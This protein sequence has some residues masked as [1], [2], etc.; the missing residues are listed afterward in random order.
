MTDWFQELTLRSL[1]ETRP[2]SEILAEGIFSTTE[3]PV[4]FALLPS[5]SNTMADHDHY[6]P[7]SQGNGSGISEKKRKH[8]QRGYD[9]MGHTLSL[10]RQPDLPEFNLT[11]ARRPSQDEDQEPESPKV[12]EQLSEGWQTVQSE[13]PKKKAKKVPKANSSNYPSIK[14]SHTDSRLQSQV[15]ISDIQNL[16]LYILADG[17][18]PQFVSVRHRPEI[19]KV[20]VLMVPGLEKSMFVEEKKKQEDDRRHSPEDYYPILLK[21][22]NLPAGLEAFADMFEDLWPVKTPGDDKFGKMH[23]PLHAILTAPLPKDKQERSNKK[24]NKG[25]GGV[26]QAREPAGWKNSRTLITEFVHTPEELL[27]NDYTLHP[28]AYGDAVDESALATHR[29][30]AGVLKENGWVDTLVKKLEDG[31]V[32]D[33]E[34]EQGSLTAGREIF[35]MDCEMCMTG[36]NEFSLTRISLVGLDGSVV[37]DELVKPAKPITNYLTQ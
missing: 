26:Q 10:L 9:S 13:H 36:E 24:N 12:G 1:A 35:A 2:G 30:S 19:R 32:P 37:L 34:I 8:E 22:E 21:A 25:G 15:K 4:I 5:T 28:A 3:H 29:N 18:S 17:P 16:V 27:E 11:S 14:F 20:V 33:N 23:S 6:R 7:R 31:S